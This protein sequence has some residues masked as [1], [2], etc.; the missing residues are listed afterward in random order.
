M[1][2]SVTATSHPLNRRTPASILRREMNRPPVAGGPIVN[3]FVG[4]RLEGR[5]TLAAAA[6]GST[7]ATVGLATA[8]T[9]RRTTG[10]GSTDATG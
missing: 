9:G 6:T 10:T 1:R 4:Y 7:D 2:V 3:S 5:A 8:A